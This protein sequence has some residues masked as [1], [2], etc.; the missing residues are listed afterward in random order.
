MIHLDQIKEIYEE[1][2]RKFSN[3]KM[4]ELNMEND[5][6]R[7]YLLNFYN[8]FNKQY[9]E[10]VDENLILN[11]IVL[12]FRCYEHAK[13]RFGKNHIYLNWILGKKALSR[14]ERKKDSWLYWNDEFIKR[15]NIDRP[16]QICVNNEEGKNFFNNIE[17][18]R[19]YNTE[20][21]LLHCVELDLFDRYNK[22]CIHCRFKDI[23]SV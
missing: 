2:Y 7:K 11:F 1:V 5:R 12:Q 16:K 10:S 14:W 4:F 9:G 3:E 18:R 8:V 13:T 21:G 6:T 20:R 15:Y 23:C 17:R 19:F 22:K